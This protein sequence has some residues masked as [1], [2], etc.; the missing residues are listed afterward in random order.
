MITPPAG[1]RIYLAC[2]V[3]DM[4]PWQRQLS[5]LNDDAPLTI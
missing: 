1:V 4:R 3:T 2:G 5:K